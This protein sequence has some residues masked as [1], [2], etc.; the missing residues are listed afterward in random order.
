MCNSV[1]IFCSWRDSYRGQEIHSS[2]SSGLSNRISSLSDVKKLL[3]I[4]DG[5]KLCAGNSEAKHRPV[6]ASRKEIFK[7]GSGV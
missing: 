7:D 6:L 2:M 4:I 3:D 1:D 5:S